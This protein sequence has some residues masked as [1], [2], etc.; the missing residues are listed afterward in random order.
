MNLV[1]QLMTIII[2]GA[3]LTGLT[4][5]LLLKGKG[6]DV[7]LYEKRPMEDIKKLDSII[8]ITIQTLDILRPF[9]ENDIFN[10]NNPKSFKEGI[11]RKLLINE[12]HSTIYIQDLLRSLLDA[13]VREGIP[14]RRQYTLISF[15]RNNADITTEAKFLDSNSNI[16]NVQCD[17]L[18]LACG[19]RDIQLI[20]GNNNY[21]QPVELHYTNLIGARI[22][23]DHTDLD[24]TNKAA[25]AIYPEFNYPS[26]MV[27]QL[28]AYFFNYSP[29]SVGSFSLYLATLHKFAMMSTYPP[30]RRDELIS[31]PENEVNFLRDRLRNMRMGLTKKTPE[32]DFNWL[33]EMEGKINKDNVCPITA[34]AAV[35]VPDKSLLQQGVIVIG[36]AFV[37]SPFIFGSEYNEHVQQAYPKLLTYLNNIKLIKNA[38]EKNKALDDFIETLWAFILNKNGIAKYLSLPDLVGNT[39][40]PNGSRVNISPKIGYPLSRE[41]LE[42]LSRHSYSWVPVP[43]HQQGGRL[44]KSDKNS[45]VSI[46]PSQT[47]NKKSSTQTSLA[48]LGLFA[49][50][51]IV[52]VTAITAGLIKLNTP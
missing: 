4:Y 43:K 13:A 5:A 34:L 51:T 30:E 8:Y 9:I 21:R 52:G 17:Q 23:L 25:I 50:A 31:N 3:G 49:A 26:M 33:E 47:Q 15:S 41:L 48:R 11:N 27:A 19:N 6:Y 12:V 22:Q 16:L 40:L 7:E 24:H 46:P 45:I 10:K 32:M 37:T 28:A 20:L 42:Q 35:H 44:E 38:N 36:D 14:V 2:V 29:T 1:E 39:I 18:L